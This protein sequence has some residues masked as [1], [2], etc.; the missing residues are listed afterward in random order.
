MR[1]R[2]GLPPDVAPRS[3]SLSRV[4]AS[5]AGAI[6]ERVAA[7]RDLP[8]KDEAHITPAGTLRAER[9]SGVVVR[10]GS[11][12]VT[13]NGHTTEVYSSPWELPVDAVRHVIHV[14]LKPADLRMAAA[15]VMS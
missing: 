13:R 4:L 3:W 8:R 10:E 5:R 12:I 14:A 15:S 1:W 2:S 6:I 9:I 11:N 7:K